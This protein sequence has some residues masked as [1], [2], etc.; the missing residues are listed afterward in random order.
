M[1]YADI[2]LFLAVMKDKD[3][4][5]DNAKKILKRYEGEITTS[6]VTF[7]ELALLAKRYNLDVVKIFTSVISIC[8]IDDDKLLKAAIY[9]KDYNLNVFDS[10]HAAYCNGKIISSDSIYE[11]VGIKRIK[12][13]D[14]NM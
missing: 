6:I 14:Q 10:F 11:R 8:S 1:I 13:E 9:M 5:K 12:L 2:D 7:I 3:W 4:L